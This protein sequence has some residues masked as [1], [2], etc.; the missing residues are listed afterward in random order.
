MKAKI[1]LFVFIALLIVSGTLALDQSDSEILVPRE[2]NVTASLPLFSRTYLRV[3]EGTK[4]DFNIVDP[5]TNVVLIRNSII[6]NEIEPKST[7]VQLSLDGGSY[8]DTELVGGQ[9]IKLNYTYKFM[10]FMFLRQMI[11]HYDD[12]KDNRNIVLFFNVPFLKAG[13]KLEGDPAS[14]FA[15]LDTS[16]VSA[17]TTTNNKTAPIVIVL[18]SIVS[19]L[20][21]SLLYINIKNFKRLKHR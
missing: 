9:D 1:A 12:N 19:L 10:P 3:Y 15:S 13:K 6:I 11:V 20:V 4:I 14:G 5:D 8:Q 7:K 21:L 18:V 16:K 17:G 2:Q